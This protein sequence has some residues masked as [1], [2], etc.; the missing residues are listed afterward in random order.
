MDTDT[1]A[2]PTDTPKLFKI[3]SVAQLATDLLALDRAKKL[4]KDL[5]FN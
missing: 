1:G 3:Y 2:L 4:A 5:E